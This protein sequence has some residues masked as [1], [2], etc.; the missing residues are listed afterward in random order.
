MKDWTLWSDRV[1]RIPL[2]ISPPVKSTK[3]IFHQSFYLL[4]FILDRMVI[5]RFV[6]AAVEG[7]ENIGLFTRKN[8]T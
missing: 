3:Q 4:N 5:T 1:E 7:L 2:Q 8:A 6:Y